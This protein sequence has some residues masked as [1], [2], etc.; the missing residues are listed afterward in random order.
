MTLKEILK[1]QNLTDEQVEAIEASMKENKVFT[2]NEENL[3]IR[4]SKL[5]DD[6]AALEAEKAKAEELIASLQANEGVNEE[7][8]SKVASYEK[9]IEDLKAAA[10]KAKIDYQIKTSLLEKGANPDDM[11]YLLFKISQENPEVKLNESEKIE[12]IDFEAVQTKYASHFKSEEQGL[13]KFDSNNL[14][15]GGTPD[16]EPQDLASALK[17]KFT[18]D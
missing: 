4:Y 8:K 3:D 5:K 6:K 14:P 18:N 13:K 1:A 10:V 7:I 11:D 9:E 16:S 15:E 12:G 2:T 17:A